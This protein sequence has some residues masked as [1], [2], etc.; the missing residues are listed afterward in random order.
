VNGKQEHKILVPLRDHSSI[1]LFLPY[2]QELARPGSTIVFLVP[3]SHRRFRLITDQLLAINTGLLVRCPDDHEEMLAR[4]MS[5]LKQDILSACAA[6]GQQG[7]KIIISVFDGSLHKVVRGYIQRED[8]HLIVLR[9]TAENVLTRAARKIGVIA[10]LC[11]AR[12]L[13]PVVLSHASS[14][15]PLR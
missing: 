4:R 11:R 15:L 8:A 9:G 3:I 13:P 14:G 6:L 7:V 2:L 5:S 10:K 1:E 12:D